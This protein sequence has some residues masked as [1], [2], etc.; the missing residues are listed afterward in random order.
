MKRFILA[1]GL[2]LFLSHSAFALNFS[3]SPQPRSPAT[4]T[5]RPRLPARTRPP[6]TALARITVY[7][8]KGRGSDRWS[9]RHRSSTG[10][11]LRPGAC[12]VDARRIPYGSKVR[13]P[14]ASLIAVD[15]GSAVISRKAA[16]RSGR[17][18]AEKAAIVID[19]FF[20]TR[21]EALAWAARNPLFCQVDIILP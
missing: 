3:H 12:A 21:R 15:T 4:T 18:V 10:V 20:E 9:R 2:A 1:F 5:Y 19:R 6:H 13:L 7:W 17:T 14:D 16:R 8:A 11:T